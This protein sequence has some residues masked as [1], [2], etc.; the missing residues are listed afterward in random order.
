MA[1]IIGIIFGIRLLR[2]NYESS[3]LIRTYAVISLI[4][5]AFML[6]VFLILIGLLSSLPNGIILGI[7]FMKEAETEP[8][9]EFV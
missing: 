5:S 4:S 2:I 1:G 9:V 6:S 8:Q 3:S 7:L